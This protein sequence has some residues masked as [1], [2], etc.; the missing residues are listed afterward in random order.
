MKKQVVINWFRQ[1]LRTHDN[2]SLSFASKLNLPII[3]IFVLDEINCKNKNLGSS[4]KI[5]LYYSL[6]ALNKELNFKLNF[7]KNSPEIIFSDLIKEYDIMYVTWNRCYEPWIINR[8]KNLKSFLKK[9]GVNVKTFN[10]NLLWEPWEILKDDGTPYKVFSPFYKRGCLNAAMPRRP[11]PKPHLR[12]C[13]LKKNF[14]ELNSLNLLPSKHWYKKFNRISDINFDSLESNVNNFF[15]I[16]IKNYKEGRNLPGKNNVSRLSPFIHFGQISPN[17]LWYKCDDFNFDENVEHFKTELGWREFSYYLLY[18]F[19]H[20][21][22]KN[23]QKKFDR[24][25]WKYNVDYLNSWKRG[26]TGYPIVDAG[27]RELWETGYMH[28]R[29]R[30]IVGSFLVKNLLQ[31]WRYGEQWFWDCLFDADLASNSAS[32]QWVAGSGADA[33]PYFRIFNPVSQ[34]QRFDFDGEYT[35]RFLPE[36]KY[37]P[38]KFLFNPWEAPSEILEEANVKL[39]ENYPLPIVDLKESRNLALDAFSTIRIK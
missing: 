7:F 29:V 24:F 8:D 5:W 39:G 33:A 38:L 6:K 13:F 30:M 37:L 36:L 32:W 11:I 19:P 9:S 27:M 35:R 26:K 23:L 25:P 31:D 2:P 10:S 16:G 15:S 12:T 34:G 17:F 3:N 20:L 14:T 22:D 4:S 1:D 28:N 18:H 21:P